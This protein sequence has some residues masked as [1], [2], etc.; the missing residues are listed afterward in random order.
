MAAPLGILASDICILLLLARVVSPSAKLV[1]HAARR[2]RALLDYLFCFGFPA[3]VIATHVI[4]QPYRFGLAVT[5][6]CLVTLVNTW[7]TWICY[8]IW[9]PLLSFA[10][11]LLACKLPSLSRALL[12]WLRFCA[13]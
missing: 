8:F 5:T 2:R 4:Y 7:P 1:T 3:L 11:C 12:G 6:G 10:G 9:A 13:D